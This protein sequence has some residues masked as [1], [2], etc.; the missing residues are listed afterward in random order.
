M[1]VPFGPATA[2]PDTP[3]PMPWSLPVEGQWVCVLEPVGQLQAGGSWSQ[4]QSKKAWSTSARPAAIM[5]EEILGLAGTFVDCYI[6]D[7][8]NKSFGE[9]FPSSTHFGAFYP[10]METPIDRELWWCQ[11]HVPQIGGLVRFNYLDCSIEM[12]K[13][14][15]LALP[16][17]PPPPPPLPV[18]GEIAP[19]E[20]APFTPRAL[21]GA[22]PGFPKS[23]EADNSLERNAEDSFERNVTPPPQ[24]PSVGAPLHRHG[25]QMLGVS[26]QLPVCVNGGSTARHFPAGRCSSDLATPSSSRLSPPMRPAV[27]K[28]PWIRVGA[29]VDALFY[30]V[31]YPATVYRLHQF[32]DTV[33]VEVMWCSEPSGSMLDEHEVKPRCASEPVSDTDGKKVVWV[34][35]CVPPSDASTA[36]P[37]LAVIKKEG[38]PVSPSN[39]STATPESQ[40]AKQGQKW[41][42]RHVMISDELLQ[43]FVSVS[44]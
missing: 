43:G 24:R 6:C 25:D 9:H 29:E 34:G 32:P 38:E 13:G 23:V 36:T 2:K 22:C 26:S 21:H 10:M 19:E 1:G 33:K 17:V 42:G 30:G 15:R 28:A 37:H 20:V 27:P 8:T 40:L 18:Q 11:W 5:L 41:Q 31:W 44:P 12:F 16:S 39:A 35:E 3:K 4:L 7:P 14:E